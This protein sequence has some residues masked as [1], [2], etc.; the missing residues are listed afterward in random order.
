MQSWSDEQCRKGLTIGFV[1]TMGALHQGHLELVK[2]SRDRVDITV[3]SIFVNPTQF[4]PHED[5]NAYPRQFESDS[6]KLQK[7]NVDVLFAPTAED[8]YG[9]E[10]QTSIDIKDVSRGLC[11]EFRPGHF[12][13]VATVVLKL[14]NIVKP[15]VA[16]FGEKD[17]QQLL[18]IKHMVHDLNLDVDIISHPIVRDSD[19]LAL[20]SRNVR[21]SQEERKRALII[22]AI[23]IRAQELF[24]KGE[25]EVAKIL[26]LV[27]RESYKIDEEAR[28]LK[29]T[30]ELDLNIY[31]V[32]S[33]GY[34]EIA[35]RIME[36]SYEYKLAH[37]VSALHKSMR[38]AKDAV[39]TY[40]AEYLRSVA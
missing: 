17:Y 7:K 4:G 40:L 13:G 9:A 28:R 34:H 24:N 30:G 3:V 29:L 18:V 11:G 23:L 32:L 33:K 5:F 6:E 35:N 15:H 21:L 37:E 22:P 14:F 16:I 31:S 12:Q 20:S 8:M 25:R 1:P 27:S 38:F 36:L 2:L 10:F 39:E 19:G 26:T